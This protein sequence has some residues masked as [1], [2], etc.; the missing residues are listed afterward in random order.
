[1]VKVEVVMDERAL[2]ARAMLNLRLVKLS[3]ALFF[4][5]IGGTWIL[6]SI[7][8]IFSV[9]IWTFIYAGS[10]AILLLLNLL[11]FVFKITVSRFTTGL[12]LLGVI[13]GAG[14]Y[15]VPGGISIWAAIVLVI[16]FS[17]LLG[18]LRK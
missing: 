17:M 18:T 13:M 14:N 16:G 6:D 7:Y 15:L 12:G 11:R 1:M 9:Q 8:P 10:G 5:L 3:W 2:I 4:I